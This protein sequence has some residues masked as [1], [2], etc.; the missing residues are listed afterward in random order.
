MRTLL[1]SA[2]LAA[3]LSLATAPA[4]AT[5]G[6]LCCACLPAKDPVATQ[7]GRRPMT[8]PA[9]FCADIATADLGNQTQRC[10]DLSGTLDCEAFNDSVPCTAVLAEQGIAC[11]ASGAPTAGPWLLTGLV[12]AL[13]AAG[14][15]AT[16]RRA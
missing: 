11:P 16:R 7:G 8:V 3:S 4:P 1:I 13:A 2:V 12:I 10:E 14:M 9:L 15:R 6:G 5:L